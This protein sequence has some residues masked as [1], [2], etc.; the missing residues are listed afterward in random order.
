MN[1]PNVKVVLVSDRHHFEYHGAL[2]RLVA[3]HSPLEVCIP[4]SEILDTSKVEIVHDTIDNVETKRQRAWG[5]SGSHYQYDYLVIGLGA[6]T[7][8]FGVPGLEALAHGIKTIRSA[9]TLKRHLHQT[10]DA[11]E[12]TTT[13]EKLCASN[14]V[15]IGGGATGTELA[16]ELALYARKLA[17]KHGIEPEKINIELIEAS[18][19]LL[20]ALPKPL[21]RRVEKKLRSIGVNVLLGRAVQR[22]E[23][24]GVYLQDMLVKSK[25]VVWTA[26]VQG[27]KL[28]S[29][30]N[31]ETDKRGRAVV[32]EYLRSREHREIYIA[33]DAAATER[34]GMAQ[35]ALYDGA[36]IARHVRAS[37]L[38]SSIP[39]Y[40]P[41]RSIY[42]IPVGPGWAASM[43]GPL[44]VYGKLGW[45]VR[46]LVDA[47]VYLALLPPHKA[48]AAYRTHDRVCEACPECLEEK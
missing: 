37:I 7:N 13:D 43:W 35:T 14:I 42:A 34:S 2:Y 8:F 29:R 16:G 21:A 1:I 26:G 18:N 10:L 25:T 19:Q 40:K 15:I 39:T 6:E 31:I 45:A 38:G 44:R 11:C 27:P 30:M 46:R 48:L 36:F 33:G 9:L 22:E 12:D 5:V 47:V 23:V 41:P 28:F 3:G 17:L 32:D 24:E 4:L 20:P